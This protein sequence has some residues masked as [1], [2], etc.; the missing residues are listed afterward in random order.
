MKC[1]R[2][3]VGSVYGQNIIAYNIKFDNGFEV[4]ILN[5]GGVITKIITPDKDNNFENIVLAYEDIEDYIEN[6]NYYGAIIGRTSGR[7]CNGK[8]TIN[9]RDYE[10]NKNYGIHQGHGGIIG[11]N[12][13]I[14]NINIE[15]NKDSVIL[16]LSTK[17]LDGEENYPGNLDVYVSFEIYEDYRI[18]VIYKA[19]SDKTTLVNITNHSYFN[20][21]G[22]IKRPI[23]DS[24]LKL[25][26]DYFLELD[27]TS[28]PTGKI[29]DVTNTP[30]DFRDIKLIGTNIDDNDYE[31]IKIGKGYDHPFLLKD[32]RKIYI[33]DK[34]CKRN[35]T[36][37]TNQEA[38]VIY[39]MNYKQYINTY[40]GK[41][42]EIRH[43]ICFETQAPPIGRNMCF[44][45]NSI[46]NKD[47]EYVQKTIY[48]FGI[49]K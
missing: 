37:T 30:F 21:S 46:L 44:L 18:E 48:K 26:C 15:E 41:D 45:E 35:M 3:V 34:Y 9:D 8:V 47:E 4:E 25:D 20:L 16:S 2:S 17:S 49:R 39:T 12:K 7:I 31:Q 36:I 5:L 29:L 33:E 1:T 10:L 40:L 43:G 11:F 14:W 6:P 32:N 23:T 13:K 42:P 38:V 24:Y 19:K 27:D 28:V 22:N